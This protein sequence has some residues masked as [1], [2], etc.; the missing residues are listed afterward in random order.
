MKHEWIDIENTPEPL[1]G[2]F[3]ERQEVVEMLGV[4]STGLC[5]A[6]FYYSDVIARLIDL[7]RRIRNEEAE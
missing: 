1:K 3:R 4:A 2:L 5:A 6:N 7:D